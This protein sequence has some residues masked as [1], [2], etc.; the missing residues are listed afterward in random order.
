MIKAKVLAGR[1]CEGW[2]PYVHENLGWHYRAVK[3]DCAVYEHDKRHYW[4]DLRF[5][6]RQ[7]CATATTPKAAVKKALE[8][9]EYLLEALEVDISN[10]K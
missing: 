9:A 6:G 8:E 3:G 2:M 10:F 1:L 5:A 7:F 4:A